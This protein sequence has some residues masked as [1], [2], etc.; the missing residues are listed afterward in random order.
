MRGTL[1][2]FALVACSGSAAKTKPEPPRP[3][4]P[5][6]GLADLEGAWRATDI[7]GWT[8]DL[9]IRAGELVQTVQRPDLGP[10]VQKGTVKGF[11]DVFG[12]PYDPAQFGGT[13]YAAVND[14]TVF[15]FV[16]TLAENACNADYSGAQLIT[17]AS[18]Y[19]G[20]DITLRTGVGHGG[21]EETRTY[22]RIVTLPVT[23]R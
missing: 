10:C 2:A 19:H 6:A 15:A 9:T 1:V 4:K 13:T 17:L 18:D 22:Q 16:V 21:A 14:G 20:D 5:I 11:E 7:D 3:A 23:K 8:F 12:H